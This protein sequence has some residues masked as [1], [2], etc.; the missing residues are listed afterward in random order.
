M[1]DYK[2]ILVKTNLL[3][4]MLWIFQ[5]EMHFKCERD[6]STVLRGVPNKVNGG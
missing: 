6:C 5:V 1:A 3:A 4:A 2:P